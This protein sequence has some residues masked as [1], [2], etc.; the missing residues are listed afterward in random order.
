M[1]DETH[2][3]RSDAEV[4][5]TTWHG[6]AAWKLEN[7][8]VQ[9]IVVPEMGAKIV[10]LLDKRNQVEWLVGPGQRP[11]KPALYGAVFTDQDMSG[12]D[13]M[14]PTI[15]ACQAPAPTSDQTVQLPDHGEVW[16]IPW[17]RMDAD[18]AALSFSVKG[19]V[20]SYEL[21]RTISFHAEDI[22][23]FRYRVEN[24]STSPLP[25]IWAAHPQFTI[26]AKAKVILPPHITKVCNVLPEEFGFGSIEEIL[27][28]PETTQEDGEMIRLDEVGPPTRKQAR[29]FY[30]TLDTRAAWIAIIREPN[31]DWISLSWNREE[32]PYLGIWMDEGYISQ[33]SVIAP[34]PTTGYYD[35]LSLAVEKGRHMVIEPGKSISWSLMVR[36]GDYQTAF[37]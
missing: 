12:W 14:F 11:F 19:R 20:L 9:V 6:Q 26:G 36:F 15:N 28:W 1:P 5:S 35:S 10:S 3:R 23:R 16:A 4:S 22:L 8:T 29:K 25:A 31:R 32:I 24:Q 13:E 17:Q 7:E 18:K 21:F 34:E 33:E 27:D 37:L 30:V 2:P